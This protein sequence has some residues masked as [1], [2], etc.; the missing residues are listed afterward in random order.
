MTTHKTWTLLCVGLII[1]DTK[2]DKSANKRYKTT[3]FALLFQ[4]L[5]HH[6]GFLTQAW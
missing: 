1:D 5:S 6:F 2:R 3:A 4:S